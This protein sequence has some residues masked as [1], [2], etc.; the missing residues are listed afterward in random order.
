MAEP[1]VSPRWDLSTIYP[2][3]ES[4]EFRAAFD[5]I[6]QSIDA[7]AVLFDRHSVRRRA[8]PTVDASFAAAY[9]EVTAAINALLERLRTVG[10]YI[11]CHVTT[12][13]RDDRAQSLESTLHATAVRFD[14]LRT[15]YTAW[16]GTS[17]IDALERLSRTAQSHAFA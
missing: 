2:S 6:A 12:D 10:S 11:S 8:A 4:P 17:D 7:L 9:D 14:L 5:G 15:R 3:L 13:A 1:I 16:V